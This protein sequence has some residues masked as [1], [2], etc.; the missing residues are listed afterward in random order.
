V[1]IQRIDEALE[2]RQVER[3]RALR[4]RR[5]AGVHAAALRRVEDAARGGENLMPQ[6]L[7]AVESYATVGE[8]ANVMR[9]VFGEYR[10]TVTV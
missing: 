3:V 4:V 10:E 6:I 9:T 7:N 2:R 5:D 8:I 1:P